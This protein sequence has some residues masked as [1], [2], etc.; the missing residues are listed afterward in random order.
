MLRILLVGQGRLIV[1]NRLSVYFCLC[2]RDS[3]SAHLLL[4]ILDL[5]MQ[6][7]DVAVHL[8][9]VLTLVWSDSRHAIVDWRL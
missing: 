7:H 9:E 2:F 4:E 6:L 3:L 5:L 1:S 8:L